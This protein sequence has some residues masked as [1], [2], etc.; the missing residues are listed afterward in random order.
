MLGQRLVK[1]FEAANIDQIEKM[2]NDF[3]VNSGKEVLEINYSASGN[4]Y[5]VLII[6]REFDY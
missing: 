6:Y 2:V 5:S 4:M 1:I 3:I